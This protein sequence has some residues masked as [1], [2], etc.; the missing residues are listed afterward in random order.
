MVKGVADAKAQSLAAGFQQ[1]CQPDRATD[2][3]DPSSPGGVVPHK[4]PHGPLMLQAM[5]L[6][7]VA[8]LP[9]PT[10]TRLM[11]TDRSN[12]S[13]GR[14]LMPTLAT[15]RTAKTPVAPRLA[16]SLASTGSSQSN[17]TARSSVTA[18]R[19]NTAAH[20]D[21]STPVKSFL[22]GNVTP[23][24]SSRKS[25]VGFGSSHSTPNATPS[26]TPSS[27]RP[28][29]TVDLPKEQGLG[30]SG[31]GIN[32]QNN[33]QSTNRP[34]SVVGGNGNSNAAAPRPPIANV[35][36]NTTSETVG[37]RDVSPMFFHANDART[38]EQAPPPPQKRPPVFFYAN[39][40]Q[41][42]SLRPTQSPSPPLSSAGRSQ[43]DSKFF[44]ADSRSEPRGTPPILSP[45]PMTTSPE[46]W[47]NVNP[48]TTGPASLRP[49]SPS[50]ENIHL[51]YRKGASQVIRP[52]LHSRASGLSIIPG[53]VHAHAS[54]QSHTDST[55]DHS[56][57]RS[58]AASTTIRLGHSKSASLSSI[59]SVTSLKKVTSNETP[60]IVPSPLHHENR[61]ASNGSQPESVQSEPAAH[62]EPLSGLSSPG[63]RSPA[64]PAGGKSPLE[65][66]NELAENAR[67]ERKVLDLEISNSSLL[68]I[69]RQ[70]EKEVRKQKAELRRFRRMSRAGRFS[71]DT[72]T[73]DAE[74][75]RISGIGDLSDMSEEECHIE[76][77]E[78]EPESSSES[79]IDEGAMS[80]SALAERDAAHRLKDEKRL[81]LDLSKHRELLIDSQKMNQSLKRCLNWTEEL[82]K[83]AHKALE[84][85]VRV[86]DVKL[87]GRV[88]SSEEQPEDDSTEE[89]RALL[90]PW[91]PAHHSDPFDHASIT[92]SEKTDRDSGVDVDGLK[93]IVSD[94]DVT[95]L[96][97]LVETP[98]RPPRSV[99]GL[100]ETY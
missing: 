84:Y 58:S 4:T 44:H 68:A 22:N 81:Q 67:R 96:L 86:S 45:P 75:F 9:P 46:P 23:R 48:L 88:L 38:H 41:D 36:N 69:N 62:N 91:T 10:P 51:S 12:T 42:E 98:S 33:T 99:P 89:S 93:P 95:K 6:L 18:P 70:L 16:P 65:R 37:P 3:Y 77:E 26:H 80:P 60:Q 97:S 87:G 50:K 90:S 13:N 61:V 31:L 83:D 14:P 27:T 7:A 76:E 15:T 47:L 72:I 85:Q 56:R 79:S 63:L 55:Q 5:A 73:T 39:G 20:E 35:Y 11:P 34:R 54:G 32:G 82:I 100:E 25:R 24:S 40:R 29:S 66:M 8:A 64:N 92:G 17:R 21:L 28:V 43:P 19:A 53:H 49:P 71:V 1:G 30:H 78:E 94:I 59:D 2:S 74:A 57:R 52:N